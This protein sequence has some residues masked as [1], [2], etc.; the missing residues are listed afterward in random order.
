M[1]EATE[2]LPVGNNSAAAAAA[3]T[4]AQEAMDME[5]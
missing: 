4:Q 5:L 3:A 1:T 2:H